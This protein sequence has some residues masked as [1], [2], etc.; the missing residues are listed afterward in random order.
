MT[1]RVGVIGVGA[2]GQDHIRRLTRVVSGSRVVALADVDSQ[3]AQSAAES[4]DGARVH[5]TGQD[6]IN[7]GDVEAILVASWGPTHEEYVLA[8]IRAGKPVFCE[9]PLAPAPDACLR[10]VEAE[11]ARGR[12]LVQVG[13]MRRYDAGYRAMKNALSGGTLG[14]PLL[15]HCAHRNPAAPP[16]GFTSDMMISDSAVHEID[17]VRWLFDQEIAAATVLK[18]RR[19]TRGDPALQDPLI[20]ILEMADGVIVDIEV[21]VN[22]Q[23]GYDI[24]CE[25][26]AESGTVSLGDSGDIVLTSSGLRSRPV[27][28]DWRERF[29]RA[30]DVELQEWVEAASTGKPTGPSSWDGYAAAAVVESCLEALR[31]GQRSTVR[32]EARPEL[33]GMRREGHA[34]EQHTE[35]DRGSS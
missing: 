15:A 34:V 32:L 8:A 6:L 19:T 11:L 17:L 23:Y 4:L 10:I 21:F 31:S 13:Y 33:Y 27:P 7:D 16:Y 25:V 24:R 30:Y 22:C 5:A 26:V 1:L 3:R 20:M 2:I 28:A 14:A 9:K 12:R 18:P 35:M 29:V